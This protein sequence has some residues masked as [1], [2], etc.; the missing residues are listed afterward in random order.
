MNT[1]LPNLKYDS[2]SNRAFDYKEI[3]KEFIKQE[4]NIIF[5]IELEKI[6]KK[7]NLNK[8]YYKTKNNKLRFFRG[9]YFSIKTRRI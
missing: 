1:N 6:Y 5:I 8:K 3:A 4:S 2:D 7:E 9:L